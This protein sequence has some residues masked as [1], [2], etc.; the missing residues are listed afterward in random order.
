MNN[1]EFDGGKLSSA[2]K[3]LRGFYSKLLNIVKANEALSTGEFYELMIANEHQPGFDTMLYI[4]MRYTP[5]QKVLVVANFN[6]TE[7]AT[8]IKIPAELLAKFDLT[9]TVNFT[10]LLSGATFST[11]DVN[12]GIPVV[13]GGNSGLL[14]SL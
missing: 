12:T 8:N 5:Q 1:G 14:L 2:Q 6:R 9:G 4:Y 7:R 11:A 13:I 3:E 10:D